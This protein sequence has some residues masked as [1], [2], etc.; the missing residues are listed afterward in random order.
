MRYKEKLSIMH[1]QILIPLHIAPH[2]RFTCILSLPP[3]LCLLTLFPSHNEHTTNI[4]RGGYI[5]VVGTLWWAHMHST[6]HWQ[7]S[8]CTGMEIWQYKQLHSLEQLFNIIAPGNKASS[9]WQGQ[10]K[11]HNCWLQWASSQIGKHSVANKWGREICCNV[12]QVFRMMILQYCTEPKPLHI[13]S[14]NHGGTMSWCQ[15]KCYYW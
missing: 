14:G 10:K 12:L 9:S 4:G 1:S 2:T 5:A 11:R 3:A 7:L 15:G 8:K 6:W 13:T